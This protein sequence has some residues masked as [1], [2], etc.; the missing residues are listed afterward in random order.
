MPALS[1]MKGEGFY[2]QNSS[3]Q[4]MALAAV[5]DWIHSA[6]ADLP[7]PAP[8]RPVTVAD[9]GCSEGKNSIRAVGAV[10]EALRRRTDQPICGIHCDLP[11]NNFNRLFATLHDPNTHN[12][13]QEGGR[14]RL[15]VSALAAAGS[16]YGPLLPPGSVH[17][18]LSF[19]AVEWLDKAPPISVPDHVSYLRGPPEVTAAFRR[20][21]DHDLTHFLACRAEELVRG[22]KLII[23]V[24]GSIGPQS[25]GDGLYDVFAEAIHDLVQAGRLERAAAERFVFPVYFYS[26]ADLTRPVEQPGSPVHGAF[27]I[28]AAD[29]REM[30][31]AFVEKFRA[32]GDAVTFAAEYTAF[33]RAFSEPLVRATLIGPQGD[34][35]RVEELYDRIR[36]RL[37]AEPERYLYHNLEVAVLLTRT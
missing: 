33:V 12:Y 1:G 32:S 34:P 24:P 28:E 15:N 2:D 17:F 4:E 5:S 8:P 21:A 7:L 27:T 30:P 19:F 18:A 29:A 9:Y 10:V 25:C 31:A 23:V 16:F 6:V 36:Q 20:Q 11:G 22:G 14:L 13:L 37:T 35:D 26:T 3:V